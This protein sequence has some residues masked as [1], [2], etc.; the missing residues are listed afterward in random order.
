M[1][2]NSTTSVQTTCDHD[3]CTAYAITV[4]ISDTRE[5]RDAKHR[6]ALAEDGWTDV[7]GRDYCPDHPTA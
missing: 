6:R 1:R 4:G 2:S 3:Y 5:E 7:E